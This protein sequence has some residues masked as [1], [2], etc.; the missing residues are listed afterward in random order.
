MGTNI[1]YSTV[2]H[3]T[4]Y[5]HIT[6]GPGSGPLVDASQES[7]GIATELQAVQGL[8][9]Q[10][11]RGIGTAQ[12]GAA[13]DA[14]THATTGLLPWISDAGT[15]ANQ[16]AARISEQAASFTHTRDSMPP[17]RVVPEVSFSQDPATWTA[18]HA[19]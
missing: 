15:T 18:D 13:A 12:Q 16:L 1:D 10:A 6:Q 9:A 17:P 7:Q 14:A 2:A 19:I 8:L 5:Q 3:E 4:I 11:V